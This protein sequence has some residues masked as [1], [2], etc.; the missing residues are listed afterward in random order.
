[1]N[2]D[3]SWVASLKPGDVVML[4]NIYRSNDLFIATVTRL[5]EKR[6]YVRRRGT[7]TYHEE[8]EF[9]RMNGQ[10]IPKA[11]KIEMYQPT[12]EQ[13]IEIEKQEAEIIKQARIASHRKSLIQGIR[14]VHLESLGTDQ[15]ERINDFIAMIAME[16]HEA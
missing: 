11:Y 12:S 15:L 2:N 8:Y 14:A 16:E 6:V 13:L 5:T 10:V 7:E 1:M 9:N 3:N 4:G